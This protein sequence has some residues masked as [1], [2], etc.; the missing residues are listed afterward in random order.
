MAAGA[1]EAFRNAKFDGI[2]ADR[3]QDRSPSG[4]LHG[5]NGGAARHD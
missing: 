4:G 3:E 2:T 5:L 1:G